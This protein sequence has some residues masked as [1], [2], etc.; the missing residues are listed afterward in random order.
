MAIRCRRAGFLFAA[1]VAAACAGL[2]PTSQLGRRETIAPG[3]EFYTL[4]DPSLVE[5]AGPIAIYLLKL[6]PALT[7]LASALSND[8]V[9]DVEPVTAIA[10]RRHA[11]A[12]ING[13][14]FNTRNGEPVSLLKVA[15]ELVS[16]SGSTKGA[17]IIA[18]PAQGRTSLTF[19]QLSGRVSMTATAAGQSWTVP[20]DGVDTTRERGKLM[21]YTPG[22]HADTDT[23]PAGTEWVLAGTPL[24]VVDVRANL[25]HTTIPRAG[26]V[27]SFGGL[28]VPAPLAQLAVGTTITLETTW[29]SLSG[30]S[31]KRLDG[32]DHIVTGAGL[33][34]RDG[35][36]I[37][38]WQAENLNAQTFTGTR[39]PRTMV[40]V[41]VRGAIWLAAIDGR[42]PDY[43]IGMTFADLER[44]CT[45][46][47]LRDALNLDGGGSTTMVVKD[48]VV[49]RPSDATGPRGVSDALIVTSR[50]TAGKS[51]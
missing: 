41:D 46:L 43:S 15:G 17:V 14:F 19:D 47:E 18:S 30:V 11:I 1:I 20:I 29:R 23:A 21:L 13:G 45:R 37:A 38:D 22:Y 7:Q 39:H 8:E 44:L 51:P 10:A 28:D 42:Q 48:R 50:A 2:A 27:L 32:A 24:R 6:D 3:V 4:T 33:L 12:A 35:H 5:V 9:M 40:G 49:N 36:A 34:R 31:H 25:G 16:D 26:A